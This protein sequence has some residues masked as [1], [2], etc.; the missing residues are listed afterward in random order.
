MCIRDR[1]RIE[2]GGGPILPPAVTPN[3]VGSQAMHD[4]KCRCYTGAPQAQ[5]GRANRKRM[6]S[7]T[8]SARATALAVVVAVVFL[9][10]G[11]L[12]TPNM[13]AAAMGTPASKGVVY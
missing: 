9:A 6:K 1:S 4:R 5:P 3:P 2:A 11:G 10:S 8:T 12:F 13:A 7:M